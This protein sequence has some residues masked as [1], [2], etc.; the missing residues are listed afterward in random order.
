MLLTHATNIIY[1]RRLIVILQ[2]NMRSIET[3]GI[4]G[5]DS[6]WMDVSWVDVSFHEKLE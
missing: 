4:N 5:Y 6:S 2:N 3:V 1:P